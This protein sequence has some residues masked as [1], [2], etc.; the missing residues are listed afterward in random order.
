MCG[1]VGY[2]GRE[3]QASDVLLDGLRRLEYRGYDSAGVAIID[4]DVLGG[5]EGALDLRDLGGVADKSAR[6]IRGVAGHVVDPR[7]RIS[8]TPARTGA[9]P[10]H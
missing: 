9:A 7:R 3:Y 4:G 2:V 5:S 8:P 1:I 6:H 10:T